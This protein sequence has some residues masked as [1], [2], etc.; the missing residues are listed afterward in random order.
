MLLKGRMKVNKLYWLWDFP[1]PKISMSITIISLLVNFLTIIG[2]A[3][4]IPFSPEAFDGFIKTIIWIIS[5][6]GIYYGRTRKGDITWY[7]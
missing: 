4:N 7:G 2:S 3:M 5:I 1:K 6:V